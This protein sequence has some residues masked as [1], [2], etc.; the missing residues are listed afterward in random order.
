VILFPEAVF[1]APITSSVSMSPLPPPLI[2]SSD[3]SVEASIVIVSLPVPVVIVRSVVP[4]A[5]ASIVTLSV[6]R[7]ASTV[8]NPLTS[9]I[10]CVPVVA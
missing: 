10:L 5:E 1:P 3:V 6:A 2:L 8:S 9:A 4:F 7:L